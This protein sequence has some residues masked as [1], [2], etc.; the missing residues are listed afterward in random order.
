VVVGTGVRILVEVH[1]DILN[2][3]LLRGVH[4]HNNW[5]GWGAVESLR[6]HC[7]WGRLVTDEFVAC[8]V[9]VLC[10][11]TAVVS[12]ES[13]RGRTSPGFLSTGFS[14]ATLIHKS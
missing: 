13:L 8:E 4:Y 6:V 2:L 5:W 10:V 12:V 11:S 7:T 9:V 1:E 14:R 3:G